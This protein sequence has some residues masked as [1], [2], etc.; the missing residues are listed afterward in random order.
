M[1]SLRSIYDDAEDAHVA[2]TKAL[3]ALYQFGLH[4]RER[5][6]IDEDGELE[7]EVTII[8]PSHWSLIKDFLGFR[9]QVKEPHRQ[10]SG[11]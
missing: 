5:G 9:S 7:V 11:N 3:Q 2:G 4:P 10:L 8:P 6:T 1:P